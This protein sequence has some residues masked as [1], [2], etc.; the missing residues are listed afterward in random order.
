MHT[1]ETH[2]DAGEE[3]GSPSAA[4]LRALAD[5]IPQLAWGMSRSLLNFERAALPT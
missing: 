2:A 3:V 1:S 4:M 5:G